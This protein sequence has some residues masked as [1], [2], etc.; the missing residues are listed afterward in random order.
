MYSQR[1]GGMARTRHRSLIGRGNS[2][3]CE[4]GFVR[5]KGPAHTHAHASKK[6]KEKKEIVSIPRTQ[7]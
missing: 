6:R 5:E 3:F 7:M 1:T 2:R 4:V